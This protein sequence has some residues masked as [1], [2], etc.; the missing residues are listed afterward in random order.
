[1][2]KQQRRQYEQVLVL[3][4]G[5]SLIRDRPPATSTA[6]KSSVESM[7]MMEYDAMALGEGDLSQLGVETIRQRIDEASFPF[8]SA[9]VYLTGTEELL[10]QPYLV[11]EMGEQRIAVIGIT[12][13]AQVPGV[14]I[15]DPLAATREIVEQLRPR[16]DILVLLSHAGLETN[17]KIAQEIPGIHVI[18]SGGGR[19]YTSTPYVEG[20][21]LP[22]VH[23]DVPSPG[24]AGR[25][26]GLGIWSFDDG[27]QLAE[28][29]WQN[30][31]L[32]PEIVDDPAMLWWV[33]QNP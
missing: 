28:Y 19:S 12:G 7:N 17:Q 31:A 5:D 32:G 27:G 10:I 29:H 16:A 23:A 21:S 6:G 11:R 3:D 1:V 18:I 14:E 9:N 30:L 26:I 2:I 15:R 20:D 24:H 33:S 22:V 13:L 25:R 8:L 4:A